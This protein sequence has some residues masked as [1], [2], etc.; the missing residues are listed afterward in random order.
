M[1]CFG[2]TS[3]A[4]ASASRGV[5]STADFDQEAEDLFK[6]LNLPPGGKGGGNERYRPLDAI[7]RHPRTGG[8][9]FVGNVEAASNM[10][11]LKNNRITYVVNC[12]DSMPLYH[13]KTGKIRYHR[14][15]IAGW[16][17]HLGKGFGNEATKEFIKPVFTFIGDAVSQGNNVLVHCLAGAHRAG[18]T[19]CACLMHYGGLSVGSSI[20]AAKKLRPVI[21]PIGGLPELL[22]KIEKLYQTHPPNTL[23]PIEHFQ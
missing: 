6:S 20:A 21:D 9:I 1:A 18:T 23:F 16:W 15:D 10:D 17:R 2:R 13:E 19:G 4:G 8:T 11:V 5:R 14:F 3:S 12:T 22:A 7:W